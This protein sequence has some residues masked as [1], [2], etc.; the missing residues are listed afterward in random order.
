MMGVSLGLNT[1]Q[2]WNEVREREGETGGGRSKTKDDELAVKWLKQKWP[3][4][5]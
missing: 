5:S 1:E 3:S 4:E 2:I